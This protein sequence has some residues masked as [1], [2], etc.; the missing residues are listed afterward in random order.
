MT[1][2]TS[3]MS[4]PGRTKPLHGG[5]GL[6][7]SG[8]IWPR[9]MRRVFSIFYILAIG[10]GI[11]LGMMRGPFILFLLAV[12]FSA[13]IFIQRPPSNSVTG[14]WGKRPSFSVSDLELVWGLLCPDPKDFLEAF[15]GTLPFGLMLF[16]MIT[17]NEIPDYVEDRKGGKLNLVAR[18]GREAGVWFFILSLLSAYAAILMG[19]LAERI[20]PLGL[21]SMLSLPIAL[22]TI[23]ILKT[24]Y[25]DRVKMAPA[26]L[27]M[28]C[29]H[30]FTAILLIVA[31]FIEG[32]KKDALM[33]SLLL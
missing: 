15:W 7:S 8:Q 25:R 20:P 29:T 14:A 24:F 33:A 23:T 19:I 10:I 13:P 11:F 6:L 28:I 4:W 26:N 9:E 22:R 3:W 27:G 1:S 16:S 5:S 32:F 2:A 31:Y 17:I 18:F 30:N 12:G 21:I